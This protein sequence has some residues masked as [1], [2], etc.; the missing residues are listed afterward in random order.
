MK[1]P[2]GENA[3]GE[4]I[5][6]A[7]GFWID[8]TEVAQVFYMRGMNAAPSRYKGAPSSVDRVGWNDAT[9]HCSRIGMRLPT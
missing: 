1:R 6:I 4:K 9:T 5:A 3:P 2:V 7:Q 8:R